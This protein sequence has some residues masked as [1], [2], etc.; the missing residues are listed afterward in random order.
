MLEALGEGWAAH[1]RQGLLA[2][3]WRAT[4]KAL[5]AASP[6]ALARAL[7]ELGRYPPS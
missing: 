7:A 6:V 1:T 5:L 3:Q 4:S 2:D